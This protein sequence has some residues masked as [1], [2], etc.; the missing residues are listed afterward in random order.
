[1]Q[2]PGSPAGYLHMAYEGHDLRDLLGIARLLRRLAEE[3]LRDPYNRLFL[4]TAVALE[5]RAQFLATH[6]RPEGLRGDEALHA[7]VDLLC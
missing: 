1:M 7:P 6:V 5:A 4:D 3:H 2:L